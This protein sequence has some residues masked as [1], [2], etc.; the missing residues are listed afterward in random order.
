[1]DR[2][3]ELIRH[4]DARKIRREEPL[5]GHSTFRIG[6][7]ADVLCLPETVDDV[8][9]VLRWVSDRAVPWMALGNGSNVLFD[10]AGFRGVVIKIR[11]NS[12]TPGTL[13]QMD[14][15]GDRVKAGA[16]VSL[17]RLAW[18]CA[19]AGL[20]GAE[21]A[22]GIPG[23]IGGSIYGNAGAHG[24]C[25]ADL[26]EA[27]D[28]ILPP[29]EPVTLTA[30][31]IGFQYRRTVLPPSALIV[32]ARFALQPDPPE[33]IRDR[34]REYTDYRKRT[35]PSADQS[36]GCIFKN[37][38]G[39]SA[40]R[41]IDAAGCKGWQVGAAQV[42]DRHANFI[43]NHGHATCAETLR[44]IDVIRARVKDRTGVSLDLEVRVVNEVGA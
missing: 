33:T 30:A 4:L 23:V 40:G 3:A 34:I 27:V 35:Q 17:A 22:S 42:S 12:V 1:M 14:Q 16:G 26:L 7:P 37:P 9:A 28:V 15:D 2:Y 24:G 32:G 43:V 36:A 44:L 5:A 31:E 19:A 41:L 10:D 21:W 6:G 29:G 13:W 25:M 18:F 11:G 38:P 8:I 39:D 20:S